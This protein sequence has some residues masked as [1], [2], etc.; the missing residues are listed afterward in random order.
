MCKGNTGGLPDLLLVLASPSGAVLVWCDHSWDVT[1]VKESRWAA[2]ANQ[3]FTQKRVK[4]SGE[5]MRA[6]KDS[7][8][9]WGVRKVAKI[10]KER[11]ACG[12]GPLTLLLAVHI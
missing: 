10:G 3:K 1:K 11:L 5:V 4:S 2:K 9:C 12:G 8:S 7:H 6:V